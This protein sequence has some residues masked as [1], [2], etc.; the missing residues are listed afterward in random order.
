MALDR[1]T[2]NKSEAL[3]VSRDNTVVRPFTVEPYT[4]SSELV[5]RWHVLR[6][7]LPHLL[8]ATVLGVGISWIRRGDQTPLYTSSTTVRFHDT[9]ATLTSG[10]G[11]QAYQDYRF[12]PVTTEVELLRTRATRERAVDSAALQ[13][14][15]IKPASITWLSGISARNV[16]TTDTLRLTFDSAQATATYRKRTVAAPYGSEITIGDLSFKVPAKPPADSARFVVVPRE[17]AI[18]QVAGVSVTPRPETDMAD[19]SLVGR[20]PV[21]VQRALNAM[22]LALEAVSA[23]SDQEAARERRKFLD[24]QLRRTDS[25]LEI[26]RAQL[27]AFRSKTQTFDANQKVSQEQTN[28]ASLRTRRE[29]LAADRQVFTT[30]L[31][32][33]IEARNKGDPSKLRT[34]IGAP[35]VASNAVVPELYSQLQKLTLARDSLTKGPFASAASNPDLQRLNAQI[36][37]VTDEFIGAVQSNVNTFDARIAALD[38]LA[39]RTAQEVSSLPATQAEQERLQQD[40]QSTQRVADQLHDEQQR[41]RI[42]EVAQGG[43]IEVIDLA[44]SPGSEITRSSSRKLFLGGLLGFGL[45]A[46]LIFLIE[47]LNTSLRRKADVEKLLS[48]PTLGSIPALGNGS[49]SSA[50]K[51]LGKIT[52]AKKSNGKAVVPVTNAPVFESYR[53]IRTSLIF[54]NAVEALR[55]VAVTSASPGDGKSTTIANLAIAFAQQELRILVI[56]C[57]LRRGSLHRIFEVPRVPGFTNAIAGGADLDSVIRPTKYP[58]LSILTTGV[59]PPNPGELLGSHRVR[60]LLLEAQEKYD[61]ILIDTPPVLAAAD[62]SILASMVDGVILLIRVG[63]T[64]KS[65]AKTAQERLRLVGARILGTVLNDPKEMLESSEEYYYYDYSAPKSSV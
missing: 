24:E 53:A 7:Y 48:L 51:L 62:A 18:A 34:L 35:G 65:A 8:L 63:V 21:F 1:R 44:T 20:D 32:G 19:L 50:K 39:A 17:T 6:R 41:A 37:S 59:Q 60:E 2:P 42:T 29:E 47:E 14:S 55:S 27:S 28:L 45:A 52:P 4:E 10:V 33:A 58:N 40:E 25:T 57:D 64:T 26:R 12:D 13:V 43:K 49:T 9:R 61:L 5:Q 56:D 54:S 38:G 36:E 11:G 46:I 22:T 15:E 3:I 30:L 23:S 16:S 31:A